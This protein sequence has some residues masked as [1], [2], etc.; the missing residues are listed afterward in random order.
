VPFVSE[1]GHSVLAATAPDPLHLLSALLGYGELSASDK[2]AAVKLAMRL[3]LGQRPFANESAEAWMRRWKQTPNLIRALWEPLCI[4]ALN[5]PVA[6]GSAQLFATVIRR[7]FL[8]GAADSTILLSRVGLSELFAPEVKRLLEMCRGTLRLQTPVT[9]LS[10]AGTKLREINL[11]DGS[12]MQPEAVVSALPCV[13]RPFARGKQIG[14]GL[15]A[16]SGC[17]DCQP[18]PLA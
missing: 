5:E 4:A 12:S 8:A 14:A 13:A 11:G 17:A 9:G 3:R 6:T 7:S 16:D 18:A 1:K 15:R 2:M 10:F